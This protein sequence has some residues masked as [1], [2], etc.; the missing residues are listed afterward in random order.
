MRGKDCTS[1]IPRFD[2]KPAFLTLISSSV[3]LERSATGVPMDRSSFMGWLSGAEGPAFRSYFRIGHHTP[4]MSCLTVVLH[5]QTVP[6]ARS[7]IC[8]PFKGVLQQ[9]AGL[10]DRSVSVIA[11]LNG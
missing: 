5:W 1:A 7:L 6:G 4:R 10:I 3:I 9:F 11:G 8:G 2:H